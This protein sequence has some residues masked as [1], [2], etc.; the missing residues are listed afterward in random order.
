MKFSTLKRFE[1]SSSRTLAGG[2]IHGNNFAGWAGVSGSIDPHTGM[3]INIVTLKQM[4]SNVLD[5]YDHRSLNSAL[6]PQEPTTLNIARGIAQNLAEGLPEGISLE[7]LDLEEL[8]DHAVSVRAPL[9]NPNNAQFILRSTFSAAHRTHAPR[10]D[11]QQNQALYGRCNNPTGH[12]H[13]YQV[14]IG[15]DPALPLDLSAW[16]AVWQQLDHRNL[17]LDLPEFA[18]RNVVTETIARYIADQLLG[19]LPVQRVRLWETA[20]FF[21]EYQPGQDQYRL[22][23][24]Y[25]FHAAHRL[26]SP[27]LSN[28]ENQHLYGKCNRPEPHGHTYITQVAVSSQLDPLTETA[29]DITRLDQAAQAVVHPLDY[30]FLDEDIEY[31]DKH[32]STG[33]N[34]AA[35]L[36]DRF[37]QVIQPGPEGSF[38]DEIR[39]WETPNNQFIVS[40]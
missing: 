3:L 1:F 28:E 23:R 10:L 37:S 11:E 6:F 36:W 20:D 18:G 38:M 2:R 4:I 14:E 16:S 7:R 22:G 21:A 31:F 40:K 27:Y 9:N 33:E 12:G 13:N 26:E 17:S 5:H 15:L 8:E 24:R 30:T 39:V 35:Y 34:I 32:P 29:F 19:V 25:R